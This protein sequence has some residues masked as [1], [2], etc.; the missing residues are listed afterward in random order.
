HGGNQGRSRRRPFRLRT[1]SAC[2]AALCLQ[3]DPGSS[4]RLQGDFCPIGANISCVDSACQAFS[5]QRGI[6]HE[7]SVHFTAGSAVL[8][9]SVDSFFA[10]F[11][12]GLPAQVERIIC[13]RPANMLS[14]TANTVS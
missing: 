3:T 14:L 9:A 6:P 12:E 7:Y 5:T 2:N 11:L 4:C 13:L 8:P 10:G 1:V